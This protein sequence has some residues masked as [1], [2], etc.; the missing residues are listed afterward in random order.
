VS[1][2]PATFKQCDLARAWKT[3][4]A[5]GLEVTR[6]EIAPDGRIVLVHKAEA[7][8]QVPASL[9]DAW[10]AANGSR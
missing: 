6:T 7:S 2:T 5:A 8:A 10:K 4:R 3:A 1:R 9:Y